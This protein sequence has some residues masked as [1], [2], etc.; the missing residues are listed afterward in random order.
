MIK[1][2]RKIRYN[3]QEE[4]EPKLGMLTEQIGTDIFSSKNVK[5]ETEVMTYKASSYGAL[6]NILVKNFLIIVLQKV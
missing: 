5:N 1:N 4:Q 3:A 6:A 2:I